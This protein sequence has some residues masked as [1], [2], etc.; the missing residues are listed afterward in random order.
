MHLTNSTNDFTTRRQYKITSNI[1]KLCISS[2]VHVT[3]IPSHVS[4]ASNI[5]FLLCRQI[6]LFWKHIFPIGPSMV[7][8][9]LQ[10]TICATKHHA[11][12]TGC[13][14]TS[15]VPGF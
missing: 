13:I 14:A 5:T 1:A 3:L 7:K 10:A 2:Y 8:M 6:L 15:F 4:A 9:S 11:S 12:L